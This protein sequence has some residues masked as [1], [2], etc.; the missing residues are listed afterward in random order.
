MGAAQDLDKGSICP[1]PLSPT[2]PQY[3]A[4]FQREVHLMEG[5]HRPVLFSR[6]PPFS[7]KSHLLNPYVILNECGFELRRSEIRSQCF[8]L[9]FE[10]LGGPTPSMRR[11]DPVDEVETQEEDS[12][13]TS[14]G[15]PKPSQ[16]NSGDHPFSLEPFIP[17]PWNRQRKSFRIIL[18]LATDYP[19]R[20]DHLKF[21]SRG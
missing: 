3:L 17:E 1:A 8:E 5:H 16:G 4:G 11:A 19:E 12:P 13:T 14:S 10:L 2:S 9:F 15:C 18:Q 6:S 21:C 7:A 20:W